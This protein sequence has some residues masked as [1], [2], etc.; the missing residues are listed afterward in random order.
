V[1]IFTLYLFIFSVFHSNFYE[2]KLL[3]GCLVPS[4]EEH[5]GFGG[6]RHACNPRYLGFYKIKTK[7][8]IKAMLSMAQVV[9]QKA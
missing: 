9:K 1:T 4:L 3:A 8:K 6:G 2:K 7:Q 5:L